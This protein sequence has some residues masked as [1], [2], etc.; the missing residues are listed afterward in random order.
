[1]SWFWLNV[2][3]AVAFFGA[4]VAVPM[5]L[6]LRHPDPGR[7]PVAAQ[8]PVQG[9]PAAPAGPQIAAAPQRAGELAAVG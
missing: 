6:V 1:M 7:T 3:L 9:R 2:P 5:W 4:W 8:A